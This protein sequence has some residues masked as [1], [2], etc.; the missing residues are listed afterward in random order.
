[1]TQIILVIITFLLLCH[2]AYLGSEIKK[3]VNIVRSL[4]K[5]VDD[6]QDHMKLRI[7]REDYKKCNS[8]GV[9]VSK[10]FIQEVCDISEGYGYKEHLCSLHKKPYDKVYP[11]PDGKKVFFKKNVEVDE[12]GKMIN[13]K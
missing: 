8:C 13:Q 10:D 9:L 6:L 3:L 11:A 7:E 1:M 5:E 12:K 2:L 4:E